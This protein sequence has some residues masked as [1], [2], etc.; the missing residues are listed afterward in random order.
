MSNPPPPAVS[1][2]HNFVLSK[3]KTTSTTLKATVHSYLNNFSV[4]IHDDN[5]G[6][7]IPPLSISNADSFA[8]SVLITNSGGDIVRKPLTPISDYI[9]ENRITF[10]L[11]PNPLF[12]GPLSSHFNGLTDGDV[13]AID[14]TQK[15]KSND[16][17]IFYDFNDGN[18]YTVKL[19]ISINPL[20]A[21]AVDHYC[22]F[23]IKYYSEVPTINPYSITQ[24]NSS[25]DFLI[26]NLL[27]LN[28]PLVSD[29]VPV[30][31]QLPCVI[32]LTFDEIDITGDTDETFSAHL[33]MDSA[34]RGVVDSTGSVLSPLITMPLPT[35]QYTVATK[36][37]NNGRYVVKTSQINDIGYDFKPNTGYMTTVSSSYGDGV[38]IDPFTDKGVKVWNLN[39][40]V[41]VGVSCLDATA[42]YGDSA[43]RED[44][45]QPLMSV[46]LQSYLNAPDNEP[47]WGSYTPSTVT[48]KLVLTEGPR[49]GESFEYTTPYLP[50]TVGGLNPSYDI[51]LYD[52]SKNVSYDLQNGVTYDLTVTVNWVAPTPSS[53]VNPLDMTEA[54]SRSAVYENAKFS[55]AIDPV[56]ELKACNAWEAMSLYLPET[57]SASMPKTGVV[58]SCRKSN[59]FGVAGT[60]DL[61]VQSAGTQFKVEYRVGVNGDWNS[62]ARGSIT[63]PASI[64]GDVNANIRK[65]SSEVVGVTVVDITD[66]L[67]SLPASLGGLGT[68]QPPLY[69][70]L[71]EIGS[72]F[73]E[74]KTDRVFFRVAIVSILDGYIP[75]I[76]TYKTESLFIIDRPVE[77]SWSSPDNKQLEPFINPLETFLD[78]SYNTVPVTQNGVLYNAPLSGVVADSNLPMIS[79]NDHGWAVTNPAAV[80]GVVPKVNLYFWNKNIVSPTVSTNV[81][82]NDLSGSG[83]GV[84]ALIYNNANAVQLPFFMVYT[85]VDAVTP[86]KAS[87]YKSKA[88]FAPAPERSVSDPSMKGLMLLYTGTLP[89]N[90]PYNIPAHRCVKCEYSPSYSNVNINFMNEKI[91]LASI[92]TSSNASSTSAG[93]FN[94]NLSATGMDGVV[95]SVSLKSHMNF[96]LTLS[97][98]L[99]TSEDSIYLAGATI[100]SMDL[101]F[102]YYNA[103]TT[104]L[105]V[106]NLRIPVEVGTTLNY[107]VEKLYNNPNTN[108][109]VE[110]LSS[111]TSDSYTAASKGMSKSADYTVA[112]T[113]ASDY[114]GI[115]YFYDNVANSFVFDLA[116]V[117]ASVDRRIDGVDLFV[118]DNTGVSIQVAS[119]AAASYATMQ[120]VVTLL[121]NSMNSLSLTNGLQYTVIF[122]PYRD[123]RVVT[124]VDHL[125]SLPADCVVTSFVY[126]AS[127]VQ[128]VPIE[129]SWVAGAVNEPFMAFSA[130]LQLVLPLNNTQTIYYAGATLNWGYGPTMGTTVNLLASDSYA[131]IEVAPGFQVSYTVQYS[132]TDAFGN[133]IPGYLSNVYTVPCLNMPTNADYTVANT[134]A[135]DN[136]GILYLYDNVANSFVFD[137]TIATAF[138]ITRIDGV[139]LFVTD[140]TG[141]LIQVASYAAA[142][143]AT[144]QNV[145]TLLSNS[146]NSLSLTNGLQYTVIFKPYRDPLVETDVAHVY[147][148][149]NEWDVTSFVYLPLSLTANNVPVVYSWVAGA[150]NE[151]FMTFDNSGLQMA[152]PLNNGQSNHYAGATLNWGYGPTMGTTVNLLASD[153]STR[154]EVT[155]GSQVSY[156]VQHLYT[157]AFGVV[158]PGSVSSVYDVDCLSMPTK[159]DYTVA[160]TLANNSAGVLYLYDNVA[161]NFIFDLTIVS[162][163][164]NRR[165]DGVDLFVNDNTGI[166][167]QIANYDAS[168]YATMQNVVT[169]LSNSM[170]S[171]SLTTGSMYTVI[172]KPYRDDNVESEVDHL[173]SGPTEWSITSFVYL[174]SNVQNVP[175]PYSWVIGAANEPYMTFNAGLQLVLPL[176]NT[177]TIY[178][179]GATLNWGYGPTMGTT[180]NLLASDSYANIEVIP[181]SQVSYTVQYSHTD[182]FGNV[183]PG[184]LSSVYTVACLNMPTNADYTISLMSSLSGST[185]TESGNG[186][187]SYNT[188]NDNGKKSIM[189]NLAFNQL[190]T[191]RIDG[192]HVYFTSSDSH[193]SSMEIGSFTV[194]QAGDIEISL[195]S[196]S[197][198]NNY[199]SATITF[200]PFRDAHVVSAVAQTENNAIGAVTSAYPIWNVPVLSPPSAGGSSTVLNGGIISGNVNTSYITSVNWTKDATQDFTYKVTLS[201]Y[202]DGN[203][204]LINIPTTGSSLLTAVLPISKTSVANYTVLI[205]KIFK[206][207]SSGE[208]TLVFDS[209]IVDP[210]VMAISVL[211]PSGVGSLKTSWVS[212]GVVGNAII[213]S[214]FIK[215]T[216]SSLPLVAYSLGATRLEQSPT[217]YN[218]STLGSNFSIGKTLNLVMSV[219]A[220]V[221]YTLNFSN[222]AAGSSPTSLVN[223]PMTK[224]TVSTVPN[225]SL[226][227]S[228]STVLIQG[229]TSSPSLL[230]NLDAK[231]LEAEGFISLVLVLTQDGTDSNPG[232]SEVLLQFPASPSSQPFSFLN[233]V[234]TSTGNLVAGTPYSAAPLTEAPTGLSN[235]MVGPYIL[236]IGDQPS[237]NTSS[238]NPNPNGFS[239]SSLTFPSSSGFITDP[240]NLVNIMAILTSRRGTDIMVGSFEYVMPPVASAIS[241]TSN[242]GNYFINFTLS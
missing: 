36:N 235:S 176:N 115:L 218:L 18:S 234:G 61:D 150:T 26:N 10:D 129:Y 133:V 56:L 91:K 1:N 58:L 155:P 57:I 183:I 83:L 50:V 227:T 23:K 75:K 77:Y 128:N 6:P 127:N 90:I 185:P 222:V 181:G 131:S 186:H 41:I 44:L 28:C 202:T 84:Y 188:I 233:N 171:L 19:S 46:I 106:D 189:F 224:Y 134:L 80:D 166:S 145:V 81:T 160:N 216:V 42:P 158:Q 34:G 180:V 9:S 124:E 152:L 228:P 16:H 135:S 206:G 143:Y 204:N 182:A 47:Y 13:K 25:T 7:G 52:M 29:A 31:N 98:P 207:H 88:M 167:I 237:G 95:N 168:N 33:I 67:F 32:T 194:A 109:S 45:E 111:K 130:G 5:P 240:A 122:K 15:T 30:Y 17:T 85:D 123:P 107:T 64:G 242:N 21:N 94:F 101:A 60:D 38:Y 209:S 55:Q 236:T 219:S 169:L 214:R 215:D 89:V 178:Y 162:A 24:V 241:I 231:G 137:L 179:A 238:P 87:W 114:A 211:V 105:S 156:T 126:L 192:V 210:S 49:I 113:L 59:L 120:N 2:V 63:Q 140:N 76:S 163:S 62:V 148:L 48:F 116:I 187:I 14:N 200:V 27:F 232:G 104:F 229:A 144:M 230:M 20:S 139:D 96:G 54:T 199:A 136:A 184:Y 40:V 177:Q 37:E 132:Y 82:L 71:P 66:G 153:S 11:N 53:P 221:S 205:T 174:A 108:S 92:Q 191:D 78:L 79:S 190:S 39:P 154:I 72:D 65:A 203:G 43:D 35:G 142:S 100:K 201:G 217:V 4:S 239:L 212:E 22:T 170:N 86:N 213:V 112:N 110:Y 226:T 173:Y 74:S 225:V 164:A 208:D 151:P 51:S 103:V 68:S 69:F 141:N 159:A 197:A 117:S 8:C 147:S 97:F 138:P 3:S 125:Y 223:G 196:I 119:Y 146:M 70:Y 93:D 195:A 12:N 175:V 198:W 118:T 165:V 161:N 157:D 172:F 149:P 102:G 99:Q 73:D 193:I 121:S 220:K